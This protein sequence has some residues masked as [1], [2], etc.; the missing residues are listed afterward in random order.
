MC[1]HMQEQIVPLRGYKDRTKKTTDH[2]MALYASTLG[3]TP[4]DLATIPNGYPGRQ[5]PPADLPD[6]GR[7]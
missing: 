6:G 4:T 3:H 1:T 7:L 2:E 5:L